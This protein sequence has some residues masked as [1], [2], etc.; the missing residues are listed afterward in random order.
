MQQSVPRPS[1]D[2]SSAG[3]SGAGTPESI[4]L[5]PTMSGTLDEQLL[6]QVESAVHEFVRW[7]NRYGETSYDFQTFYAGRLGRYAKATYYRTPKLGVCLVA[8]IIF[9]EAFAPS[10]RRFFFV[11][12]RFPIADAHF[13]MGF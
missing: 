3:R 11:R 5:G 10:A 13:C 4:A 6:E 12:Q 2:R 8:P 7:L 1:M 9:C